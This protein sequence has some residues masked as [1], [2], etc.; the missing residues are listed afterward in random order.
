MMSR[1]QK[2]FLLALAFAELLG[3]PGGFDPGSADLVCHP[4]E[5]PGVDLF[6]LQL[7]A[8]KRFKTLKHPAHDGIPNHLS[9]L[10]KPPAETWVRGLI[11]TI[12]VLLL[13]SVFIF[14]LIWFWGRILGKAVEAGIETFDQSI[15]GVDV[16]IDSLTFNPCAGRFILDNMVVDN[17][18]GFKTEYLMKVGR[19]NVD[20]SM[21]TLL[22]SC[23]KKI[24]INCSEFCDVDVIYEKSLTTSNVHEILDF[25]EKKHKKTDTENEAKEAKTAAKKPENV[26]GHGAERQVI[27]K[28]VLLEDVGMKA[29]ATFFGGGGVRVSIG[30]IKYDDFSKE[31]GNSMVDDII[32]ILFKS[33]LKTIAANVVGKKFADMHA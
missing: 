6:F 19:I 30:D 3:F 23:G 12:L 32:K 29:A 33:I 20:V 2:G 31:V 9:F 15:I 21:T 26:E 16:N 28:K 7:N 1:H 25:M 22:C 13:I 5:S 18:K 8:V 27:L 14:T 4:G 11:C 24:V 10:M 17:P